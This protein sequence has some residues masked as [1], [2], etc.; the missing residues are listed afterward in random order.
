MARP[1]KQGLDYFPLDVD[2]DQDDKI[3][4][5][6]AEHGPLGFVIIIKL[7]AKIYKEGY[8]YK[9]GETEEILFSKRA[10]V[11]RNIT[12]DVVND[13]INYGIFDKN[14]FE[15]HRILTS[16]GIQKRYFEAVLR[17]KEVFTERK[18][19]LLN[20][21]YGVNADNNPVNANNNVVN[22]DSSTQSKVKEIKVKENKINY[23]EYVSL[24]ATEYEKLVK[25]HG[26]LKTLKFIEYLDNYK[27]LSSNSYV[28]DQ[29]CK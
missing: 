20:G 17:R 16:T 26:E 12:R 27:G 10:N 8:Y 6:E 11:D 7:L 19:L 13:C 3:Q 24:T 9:W 22:D 4:V 23:A 14:M 21:V 2:I 15:N 18:Y 25:E 29:K 1:L 5:I 28:G